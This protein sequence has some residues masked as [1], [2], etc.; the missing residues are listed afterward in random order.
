MKIISF[1]SGARDCFLKLHKLLVF[2]S[3]ISVTDF[4]ICEI[5]LITELI[6]IY[7]FK[8][9]IFSHFGD[10]KLPHNESIYILLL[11]STF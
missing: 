3:E 11:N 1:I 8:N 7:F 6:K 5:Y 4:K 2:L 9:S 10:Y